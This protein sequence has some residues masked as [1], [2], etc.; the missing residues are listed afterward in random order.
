MRGCYIQLNVHSS[1][2]RWPKMLMQNPAGLTVEDVNRSHESQ[3]SALLLWKLLPN[4]AL[5][6]ECCMMFLC[7]TSCSKT[8]LLSTLVKNIYLART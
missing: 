5:N 7:L 2:D 4:F 6:T 8:R 1:L 3:I